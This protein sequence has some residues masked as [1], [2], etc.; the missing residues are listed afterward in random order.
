MLDSSN[1]EALNLAEQGELSA[2]RNMGPPSNE[3]SLL[4]IFMSMIVVLLLTIKALELVSK[5]VTQ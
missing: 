4:Y 2:Y 5:F 3:G 1:S